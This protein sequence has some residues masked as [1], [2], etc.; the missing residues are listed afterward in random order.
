M[1]M[2][3]SMLNK[4]K[5]VIF[6]TAL[7]DA[8]G[9]PVEFVAD[10]KVADLI[11]NRGNI[12]QYSDDTQMMVATIRGILDSQADMSIDK[13]GEM[14]SMR[15]VEWSKSP[16]NNRAP[17]NAC[18]QGCR[19]M[20]NGVFWKDAGKK[21]GKGCG[22]AMRSMAYSLFYD[23]DHGCVMAA[24]HALMT[25]KSTSAQASAAATAAAVWT[26]LAGYEP[27]AVVT[28]AIVKAANWDT[29]C[30]AMIVDAI[31]MG[32]PEALEVFRGWRGDEAVAAALH[33]FYMYPDNF[34][35][36]VRAAVNS[37]GDSDSLGA[38]AG[39]ISG[40]YLGFDALPKEWVAIIENKDMLENLAQQV[41][42]RLM[43]LDHE[44]SVSCEASH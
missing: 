2:K 12:A 42:E 34:R 11:V 43:E 37:P 40:G 8:L 1:T 28:Q 20:D 7:G 31:G 24:I 9:Y 4:I 21:D 38:I 35:D 36:C 25:H 19:N 3:D 30:S 33:C 32:T 18:M 27:K 15:Y 41:Y 5:G 10:P 16:E 39:A 26:A 17:G 13:V 14:V 6:G 23:F 44:I 29:D 22:A